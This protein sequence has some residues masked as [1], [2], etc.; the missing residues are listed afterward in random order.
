M[1]GMTNGMIKAFR[2]KQIDSK[3]NEHI[4]DRPIPLWSCHA[5][6]PIT[7]RPLPAESL[8]AFGGGDGKV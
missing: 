5:G 2:L 4:R 6:G 3:G 7:T 8:V 1:V